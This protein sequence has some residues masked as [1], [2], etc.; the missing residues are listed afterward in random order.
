VLACIRELNTTP[1]KLLPG[2][3]I[4]SCPTGPDAVW[5]YA[6]LAA[7][8]SLEEA[9]NLAR[10]V[11]Q[12]LRELP[13]VDRVVSQVG[14]SEDGFQAASEVRFLVG[15]KAR[16]AGDRRANADRRRA[17]GE[18]ITDLS[19][20]L[21]RQFPGIAWLVSAHSPEELAGTFPDVPAENLLMITGPDLEQLARLA[22]Q[23]EGLL[24]GITGVEDVAVCTAG[25]Q[26][27]LEFRIDAAKC[28]RWGVSANEIAQVLET[29]LDG[30]TVTQMIEGEK[31][32]DIVLCW[33]KRLRD[34][35]QAILDLPLDPSGTS[36]TAPRGN[37]PSGALAATLPRLR[38]RDVVTPLGKDGGPD[39]A[40]QYLHPGV[41]V[42]YRI[43]G[44]RAVPVRYSIRGR[45]RAEV[46]AE[47]ARKI[48]PLLKP[49]YQLSGTD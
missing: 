41:A 16:P 39:Q 45:P 43:D 35:E 21:R 10:K 1:H 25:S 31:T 8:T 9:A 32:S 27:Y 42:I 3:H 47:V 29:A 5:V 19:P 24:R 30:K 49:P 44:V 20:L 7:N 12:A 37:S 22:G 38:L 2:V 17:R 48:A 6:A 46:Q 13:E 26:P 15:L 14:R 36:E 23:A 18:L 4:E 40:R 28:A 34:N 33:P 11:R